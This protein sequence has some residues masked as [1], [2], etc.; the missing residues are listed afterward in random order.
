MTDDD[1]SRMLLMAG[2]AMMGARGDPMSVLS[3]GGLF[4]MQDMNQQKLLQAKLL[5]EQ[6]Q[7]QLRSMQVAQ[8]QHTLD[9]EKARSGV[10]KGA[11]PQGD[12]APSGPGQNFM[13]ANPDYRPQQTAPAPAP[14]M[15]AAMRNQYYAAA[16]QLAAEGF[17]DDAQK[18]M[19]AAIKLED[20]YSTTPQT[21]MFNGKPVAALFSKQGNTKRVEGYSPKP[22]FQKI[23]IGGREGFVDPLTSQLGPM[24]DKTMSPAERDASARGWA[25]FNRG[26]FSTS[27]PLENGG[28]GAGFVKPEGFTAAPGTGAKMPEVPASIREAMAKNQVLLGNIDQALAAGDAHPQAFGAR[29]YL[30]DAVRQRTDPEGIDARA[31]VAGISGQ[32]FHDLSG[33]AVSVSEAARLQPFIPAATDDWTTARKKLLRLK[34]EATQ[35]AG[36]LAAGRSFSQ[37][38]ALPDNKASG[39]VG[40]QPSPVEAEA[41]L[42]R[43]GKR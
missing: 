24:F 6:G 22:D 14:D 25:T 16:R 36:E 19:D 30:G 43:R 42:M 39:V 40:R 8:M 18:Y 11:F 37:V 23:D 35:M 3:Q 38:G 21:M 27:V 12:A 9:R 10:L 26:E 1:T 32:K 31:T 33:A 17:G 34:S 20:E 13:G 41:E 2:L 5:E 4:A 7:S 28:T 29:N 15:R